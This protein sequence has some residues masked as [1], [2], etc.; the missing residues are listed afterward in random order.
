MLS[1]KF[2]KESA[3]LAEYEREAGISIQRYQNPLVSFTLQHKQ[4]Q[5]SITK[6]TQNK[7]EKSSSTVTNTTKTSLVV[8]A[9]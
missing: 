5:T 4:Q 6:Q 2:D 1:S 3:L 8:I 7:K 9:P